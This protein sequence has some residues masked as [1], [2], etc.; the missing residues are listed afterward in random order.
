MHS[1]GDGTVDDT[2]QSGDGKGLGGPSGD[3]NQDT[4]EVGPV[5]E[6]GVPVLD[7]DYDDEWLADFPEAIGSFNVGYIN[8]PKD[9]ACSSAPI[10]YLQIPGV[11][12]DEF[13]SNPPDITSLRTAIQSV[14]GA[15]SKVTLSFSPSLVDSEAFAVEDAAWNR[16]RMENGCPEPLVDIEAGDNG[17]RTRAYA[18]FQN[19]AAGNYTNGNAQFVRIQTPSGFGTSQNRWSVA[20]NNVVTD[21][22]YFMQHGI[23]FKEGQPRIVWT[24]DHEG[25]EPQEYRLVPYVADAWYQFRIIYLSGVWFMCAGND[26]NI[27][28]EYECEQSGHATGTHLKLDINTSVFFENANTNANWHSGFPATI[29]VKHALIYVDGNYQQWSTE[30]RRNLSQLWAG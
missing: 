12:L 3:L 2:P 23:Q 10:I 25:L 11:S 7:S 5:G 9:R 1:D 16:E 21:D 20:L 19:T 4:G 29:A 14:H 17:S 15:P 28:T 13:L 18:V 8:T 24:E 30:D 22:D 26:A 27:D 6:V